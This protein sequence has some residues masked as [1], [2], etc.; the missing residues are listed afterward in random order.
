MQKMRT[1]VGQ[2]L[3][4]AVTE[5]CVVTVGQSI[6]I[7]ASRPRTLKMITID[8][9][10]LPS[11]RLKSHNLNGAP[12]DAVSPCDDCAL[13]CMLSQ[14]LVYHVSSC[15]SHL[16][17]KTQ[18]TLSIRSSLCAAAMRGDLRGDGGR[19]CLMTWRKGD[20]RCRTQLQC[21]L[22]SRT[23]SVGYKIG[24]FREPPAAMRPLHFFCL[25]RNCKGSRGGNVGVWPH[26]TQPL[27]G[28]VC[29][30]GADKPGDI[31]QRRGDQSHDTDIQ[32]L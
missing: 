24:A 10:A 31:V 28:G 2:G 19:V 5:A 14:N 30:C 9:R 20:E 16:L 3:A 32:E 29:L 12:Q 1:Q 27:E 22:D 7:V 25:A 13:C 18:Q 8:V 15:P 26:A 17:H 6:T 23:H 4:I 11:Q 21:A